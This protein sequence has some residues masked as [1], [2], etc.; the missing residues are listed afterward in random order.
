MCAPVLGVLSAASGAMG[1]FGQHSSQ[2]AQYAASKQ[3]V[4]MQRRQNIINAKHKDAQDWD[5]Y[6]GERQIQA[7][8]ESQYSEQLYSNRDAAGSAYANASMQEEK[9]FRDFVSNSA[10]IQLQQLAGKTPGLG[11]RGGTARRLNS[12]SKARAG[13]ALATGRDNVMYG[14]DNI[15]YQKNQ[16]S[17]QWA[18]RNRE[19][20]RAV[21]IAPNPTMRSR[22]AV[23][24]PA[25]PPK[26]SSM[27]LVAG[28]GEALIGGFKTFQGLK[29]PP[30][31]G[32]PNLNTLRTPGA[33]GG[34]QFNSPGNLFQQGTA[35]SINTGW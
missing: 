20:W 22:G 10:N 31:G 1:A 29:A 6:L 17:E 15:D 21:S 32:T 7:A 24:Q 3:A 12:M 35:G 27:G 23:M 30:A 2:Q 28:L 13:E 19:N 33:Y 14:M 16:V 9:L 26:P 18:Q 5:R 25:D 4:E 8:K 34:F 11:Q